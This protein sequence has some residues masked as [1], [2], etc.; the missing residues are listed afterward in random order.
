MADM[1]L[2]SL[3]HD[4][5]YWKELQDAVDS[6]DGSSFLPTVLAKREPTLSENVHTDLRKDFLVSYHGRGNPQCDNFWDC[7]APTPPSDPTYHM[8]DWTNNTYHCVRTIDVE[9][10]SIYCRFLDNENFVEYYDINKDPWQLQNTYSSLSVEQR[11]R[12][13]R[14]LEELRIC[15]GWTCRHRPRHDIASNKKNP[16]G[17]PITL[18]MEV[19]IT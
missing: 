18:D 3:N 12:Y 9:E 15:Q 6:M 2:S 14:R 1:A 13:E 17:S 11:I 8:G 7:P 10:N 19:D 16:R 5:P 4:H